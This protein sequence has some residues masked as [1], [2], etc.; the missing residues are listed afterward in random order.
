M[1]LTISTTY[2]PA[3]DLGFL[4]AKHPQRMQTFT[5]AFGK[6]HV[7]YPGAS[8]ERCTATLGVDVDSVAHVPVLDDQKHYWV[9]DHEVTTLLRRGECW[10]SVHQE[11]ELIAY[12]YPK[13]KRHL[14]GNALARLADEGEGEREPELEPEAA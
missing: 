12:C 13:H 9:G 5:L 3:T 1:L 7:F 8:E 4:L 11:R 14:M 2:R 6:A 10:P